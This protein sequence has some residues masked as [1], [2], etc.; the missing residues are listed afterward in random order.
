M[1]EYT[2]GKKLSDERS[3]YCKNMLIEKFAREYD[4]KTNRLWNC[5]RLN[6]FCIEFEDA[7]KLEISNSN[8]LIFYLERQNEV[9]KTTFEEICKYINGLE[10]WEDIDAY[11]FDITFKWIFAITHEDLKCV[12]IGLKN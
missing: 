4:I 1:F 3:A 11:I 6:P 5:L 8:N 9:Y 12:I 10:P 2:Y 7:I